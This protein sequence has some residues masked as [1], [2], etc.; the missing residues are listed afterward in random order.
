MTSATDTVH[1]GVQ[2]VGRTIPARL[3]FKRNASRCTS[4]RGGC[5]R[6]I[7]I[8]GGVGHLTVGAQA[9]VSLVS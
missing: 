5:Q 1:P 4:R 6:E 3:E 7:E 8:G 2:P 9:R